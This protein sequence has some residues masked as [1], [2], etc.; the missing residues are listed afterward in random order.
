MFTVFTS[1][2]VDTNTQLTDLRDLQ[3]CRRPECPIRALWTIAPFPWTYAPYP[4]TSLITL[5]VSRRRLK[6]FLFH[7][8]FDPP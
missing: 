1:L 8:A 5:S 7:R 6:T 2:R 3:R 4:L